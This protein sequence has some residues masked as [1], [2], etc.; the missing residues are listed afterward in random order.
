MRL[1]LAAALALSSGVALAQQPPSFPV[2]MSQN[3]AALLRQ[4]CDLARTVQPPLMST[5][6]AYSLS[7]YCLQLFNRINTAQTDAAA[8]KVEAPPAGDKK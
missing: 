8:P 7:Q 5:E 4:M 2:Q 6:N 3:D 1:F